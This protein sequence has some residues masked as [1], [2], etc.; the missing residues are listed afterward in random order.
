MRRLAFLILLPA[1]ALAAPGHPARAQLLDVLTAPKTL[2]DRAIE[3]RSSKD[4]LEDNRIVGDVNR[5]MVDLGTIEASTE[6][7]E[8]HL[9]ITGIF[10]EKK[11]YDK[12]LAEVKKVKGVKKLYWHVTHMPEKEQEERKKKGELLAWGDALKLDASVG[13]NLVGTR[14][15]ADVNFRVAVDSY[16]NVYLMGRARSG[17]EMKKAVKVARETKGVKKL[18]N[19]AIV[20]P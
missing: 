11:T 15:I 14:G 19:Y 2:V 18:Y 4:I 1:L 8:Q 20:K 6:I 5:I 10:S 17:E 16:S 13:L 12:F 3:A 7:Y 9:L